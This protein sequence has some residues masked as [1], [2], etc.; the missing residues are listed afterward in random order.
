MYCFIINEKIINFFTSPFPKTLNPAFTYLTGIFHPKGFNQNN[1]DKNNIPIIFA[2]MNAINDRNMLN[3]GKIHN[4]CVNV[5]YNER[6]TPDSRFDL[7]KFIEDNLLLSKIRK[8]KDII[9]T[10]ILVMNYYNKLI[11][12]IGGKNITKKRKKN[13]QKNIFKNR[14]KLSMRN[15]KNLRHKKTRQKVKK[16]KSNK[17]IS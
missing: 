10:N 2:N 9:H 4:I 8:Y 6:Q 12:P 3:I 11:T 13:K 16:K 14:K 5:S 1:I 7:K 17:Y 15:K